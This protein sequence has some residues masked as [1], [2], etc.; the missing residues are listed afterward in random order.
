MKYPTRMNMRRGQSNTCAQAPVSTSTIC[1]KRFDDGDPARLGSLEISQEDHVDNEMVIHLCSC[2]RRSCCFKIC[3]SIAQISPSRS[4]SLEEFPT[5]PLYSVQ[6]PESIVLSSSSVS[7]SCRRSSHGRRSAARTF[8]LRPV[9]G[10]GRHRNRSACRSVCSKKIHVGNTLT[11]PALFPTSFVNELGPCHLRTR[12]P[13][14]SGNKFF[15][16]P[17]H[18]ESF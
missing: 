2:Q 15:T 18:R 13:I 12:N 6:R 8:P 7:V 16:S 5:Q 14:P 9:G 11:R 17:C 1:R 10:S 4:L 3:R